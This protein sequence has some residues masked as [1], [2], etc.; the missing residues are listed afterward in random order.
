MDVH[1]HG[2]VVDESLD[3]WTASELIGTTVVVTLLGQWVL[4]ALRGCLN[5]DLKR[6]AFRFAIRLPV[7]RGIADKETQKETGQLWEK[8]H[9]R[10]QGSMQT[11]PPVGLG[12]EEIL[13]RLQ[14]GEAAS[15]KWYIEDGARLSG[16]VYSAD[17]A[18]WDL[19]STVMRMYIVSNPLHIEEF[20]SVTQMEAEIVRMTINLFHGDEECCGIGTS[21]GTESIVLACLAYREYGKTHRGITRPNMVMSSTAHPAFDKA[22]NQLVVATLFV[23]FHSD[24]LY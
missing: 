5:H 11:L 12:K 21:G 2:H 15:R 20:L 17:P 13:T 6:A 1:V 9:S 23:H 24:N 3:G 18:H 10:R 22:G 4:R 19:V 14:K 16:A 8:Y 7:V